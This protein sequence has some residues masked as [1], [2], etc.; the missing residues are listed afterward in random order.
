MLNLIGGKNRS[1][2]ENFA[3]IQLIVR[4]AGM[5][6]WDWDL[7]TDEVYFSAEWK[8]QLGYELHEL[9]DAFVEWEKRLHPEDRERVLNAVRDFREGRTTVYDIE[10][11][12]RHRDGSWRW[13]LARGEFVRNQTGEPVRMM[14]CHMDVTDRKRAEAALRE[15]EERLKYALGATLDGVWDWDIP[16][17]S[18]YFSSQWSRLLGYAPEEVPQKVG[19]F[20]TVLHPAD[21]ARVQWALDEHFAGRTPVTQS[22]V[23]LRMKSGGY[24]WFLD[25]GKVVERDES[26]APLRMVGTIT[27]V[28]ERKEAEAALHARTAFFEAMADSPIDGVM[29]VDGNGKRIHQNARLSQIFKIPAEIAKDS[30][31]SLQFRFA[32]SRMKNPADFEARVS[33]LYASSTEI[34]RHEIELTDG[35]FLDYVSAPVLDRE[36]HFYGRISTYRDITE[37]KRKDERARLFFESDIQGA[38]IWNIDATILDANDAFL[39]IV[40]YSREDIGAQRLNWREMTPA[41][42]KEADDRAFEELLRTG[43]CT[44]FEKEYL[45]KDGTRVP[46]LVAG[47]MLPSSREE[48]IAVVID[49]TERKK[50]EQQFLRAQRMESIGTLAGGIAHD[51]NNVL[52][53]IMISL[54][55]LRLRFTDPASAELIDLI[56]SSASA[57]S[58][59]VK[60]VLSFAHGV[61]GKR[62]DVQVR[63]VI[64]DVVKLVDDT[65]LKHIEVISLCPAGLWIVLIDPSQLHQAL[66]NLAV[67]ARDAMPDGGKLTFSA[68]NV[69]CEAASGQAGDATIPGRYLVIEVQDTGAGIPPEILEKIFDPFFTTKEVGRGTGLG[70]STVQ[71]IVKSHGGFLRVGS[72]PGKGTK[73]EIYLPAQGSAAVDAPRSLPLGIQRGHGELILVVDDEASMRKIAS[74]MLEA[75]GYRVIVASDG[76]KGIAAFLEH[77]DEIA[78]LLIDMMMP[79]LDGP[80]AIGT[81]RKLSP[82]LPI[83]GSSGLPSEEAIARAFDLGMNRFLPKP[84]TAESLL[85]VLHL[86]ISEDI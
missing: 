30:D 11:R 6:L 27:D 54:S 10:F 1:E 82:T 24:R 28:T 19:F 21:A 18:V 61:E 53:P 71:T 68:R 37:R 57:G 5:G 9:P 65:F 79:V 74:Q 48:G 29:V 17:G 55:L 66:L 75:F 20:N 52:G 73:F 49:L 2:E 60:Q 44:P 39:G 12:L 41:E 46:V 62:V 69:V 22:E 7:V 15:S 70:L 4:A 14:G 25:R 84:Y 16:S 50:L 23:R 80:A 45:R 43:V 40:G 8:A 72:Q 86:A 13:M 85:Q 35:R 78:V 32:M 34:G 33:G 81:I 56:S 36:G 77:Q 26:G 76:A 31:D 38:L 64:Q 47:A 58:E 59:M 42:S 63:Y 51:L 67:N 83:I 3:R